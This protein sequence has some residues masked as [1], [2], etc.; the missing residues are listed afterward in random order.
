M[1]VHSPAKGSSAEQGETMSP[2]QPAV[3]T[4]G[5]APPCVIRAEQRHL[6]QQKQAAPADSE[7]LQQAPADEPPPPHSFPG[8]I[9]FMVV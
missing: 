2:E 6:Q 4:S 3:D 8:S 5:E 1:Q 7:A 9:Q